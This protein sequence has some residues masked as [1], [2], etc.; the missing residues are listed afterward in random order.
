MLG[1]IHPI[2]WR[3]K[4]ELHSECKPSKRLR[5]KRESSSI[6]TQSKSYGPT[7]MGAALKEFLVSLY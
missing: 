3:K 2:K 7:W 4:S 1:K 6:R 5:D